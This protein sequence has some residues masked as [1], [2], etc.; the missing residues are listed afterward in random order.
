MRD[1]LQVSWREKFKTLILSLVFAAIF[2]LGV[3][4]STLLLTV[5]TIWIVGKL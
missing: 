2:M 1:F 3:T 4:L 5:L